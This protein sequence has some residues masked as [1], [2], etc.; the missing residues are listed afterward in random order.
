MPSTPQPHPYT[1]HK[2]WR[3]SFFLAGLPVIWFIGWAVMWTV[4]RAV[5]KTMFTAHNALYYVGVL[6]L[7]RLCG[8]PCQYCPCCCCYCYCSAGRC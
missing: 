8:L 6:P 7:L 1:H 4:V 2:V 5:E 3:I